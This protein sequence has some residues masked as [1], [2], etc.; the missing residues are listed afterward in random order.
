MIDGSAIARG[1]TGGLSAVL[2]YG[3]NFGYI[4]A[5]DTVGQKPMSKRRITM[6]RDKGWDSALREDLLNAGDG[7]ATEA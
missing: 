6:A 1:E 3:A 4:Y 7:R 5:M 2:R